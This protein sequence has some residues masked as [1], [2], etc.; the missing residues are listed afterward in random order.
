MS[1]IVESVSYMVTTMF[2]IVKEGVTGSVDVFGQILVT[3][4]EKMKTSLD[5]SMEYVSDMSGE[6]S[7]FVTN[8]VAE[9]WNNYK[10]AVGYVMENA[11]A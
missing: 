4:S 8:M 2:E 3:L 5:E 1:M 11:A 6:I 7:E 9:L 10:E